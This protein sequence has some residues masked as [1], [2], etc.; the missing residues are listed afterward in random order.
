MTNLLLLLILLTLIGGAAAIGDLLAG[1]FGLALF[2]VCWAIGAVAIYHLCDYLVSGT[3]GWTLV[4]SGIASL[5]TVGWLFG[6]G[7]M[8]KDRLSR[9]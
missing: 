1:L 2:I 5:V 3:G 4:F 7:L 6:Q 8:L 9:L